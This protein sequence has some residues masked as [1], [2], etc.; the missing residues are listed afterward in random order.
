MHSCCVALSVFLQIAYLDRALLG[1]GLALLPPL[2]V[3]LGDVRPRLALRSHHHVF[4]VEKKTTR[5]SL[6]P[7]S[8]WNLVQALPRG[9]SFLVGCS[10]NTDP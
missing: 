6:A 2:Y 8:Q 10:Q 3:H 4:S 9:L 7:P 5:S 1:A